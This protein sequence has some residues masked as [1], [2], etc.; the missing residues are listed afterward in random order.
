VNQGLRVDDIIPFKRTSNSAVY[1]A[2]AVTDGTPWAIKVTEYKQRIQREFANR[3]QIPNSPYLLQ[4]VRCQEI[5]TKAMLQMEFCEA[6]DLRDR[7]FPEHTL[8]NL[9]HDIGCALAVIH[10]AN[11]MHLDVSPGNI[12]IGT[13][14]FKLADF[15]TLT[16][17][18]QFGS[19]MEGAGPYASPEALNYPNLG[20]VG[21]PTDIFSFGLVLVEVA[22]GVLVPRGGCRAYQEIRE[23]E[24]KLGAGKYACACSEEFVGLVNSMLRPDPEG[25][26]TAKELSLIKRASE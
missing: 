25:R 9:V 2:T 17:F 21:A 14:C 10:E 8:W 7:R 4:T 1:Y 6:G 13:D 11:W 12:L 16:Q 23:G 15:A 18:G 24:W 22:T 5:P 20:P 26:P 19:G 3:K